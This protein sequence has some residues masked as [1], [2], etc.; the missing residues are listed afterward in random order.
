MKNTKNAADISCDGKRNQS[1]K[2]S[3]NALLSNRI[4]KF[5]LDAESGTTSKFK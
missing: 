5:T 4:N 3:K 1:F 2:S